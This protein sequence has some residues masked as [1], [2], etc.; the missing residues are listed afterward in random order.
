M[1]A[2]NGN[3]WVYVLAS[4]G[5]LGSVRRRARVSECV[6]TCVPACACVRLNLR[7][8]CAFA[9]V[10]ACVCPLRLVGYGH[11]PWEEVQ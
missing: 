9:L 2:L 7:S 3:R 10:S 6:R 4:A 8:T 11:G 1:H 5:P